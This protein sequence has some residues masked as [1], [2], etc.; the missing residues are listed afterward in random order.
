MSWPLQAVAVPLAAQHARV[1]GGLF[2]A[3]RAPRYSRG[4]V[5]HAD[6][7]VKDVIPIRTCLLGQTHG[8]GTYA[9]GESTDESAVAQPRT[10]KCLI[11][12]RHSN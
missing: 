9:R 12:R 5:Y 4:A 1:G 2:C 7:M 3:T 6:V 11:T 8:M 10:E